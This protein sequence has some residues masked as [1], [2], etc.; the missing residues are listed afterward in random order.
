MVTSCSLP[1]KEECHHPSHMAE[2]ADWTPTAMGPQ[3]CRE[4]ME[5][6]RSSATAKASSM[7]AYSRLPRR[8]EEEGSPVLLW[9]R[10]SR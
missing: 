8:L 4:K 9:T 6:C 5:S 1:S 3:D 7:M 10:P 2:T